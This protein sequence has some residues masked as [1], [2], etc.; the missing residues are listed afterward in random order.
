VLRLSLA[1]AHSERDAHES[2]HHHSKVNP[3]H[4][5]IKQEIKGYIGDSSLLSARR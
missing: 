3:Q 1:A 4:L 5:V 2:C